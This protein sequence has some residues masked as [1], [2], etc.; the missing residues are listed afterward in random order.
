MFFHAFFSELDRCCCVCDIWCCSSPSSNWK[1]ISYVIM[2]STGLCYFLNGLYSNMVILPS[3][4]LNEMYLNFISTI[5]VLFKFWNN[6]FLFFS[7]PCT[8]GYGYQC[9]GFPFFHGIPT[10]IWSSIL[11]WLFQW[12]MPN[13]CMINIYVLKILV[14]CWI[15]GDLG[16]TTLGLW[17]GVVFFLILG[18]KHSSIFNV[19]FFPIPGF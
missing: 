14:Y 10:A 8:L 5:C 3:I 18:F 1:M 15:C 2:R 6:F 12:L 16:Y 11:F 9:N 17:W 7:L 4:R 19:W 13:T